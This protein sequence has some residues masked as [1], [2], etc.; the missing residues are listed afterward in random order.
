MKQHLYIVTMEDM[1]EGWTY[2]HSIAQ[3]ATILENTQKPVRAIEEIP[4]VNAVLD[5][6][7]LWTFTHEY[8]MDEIGKLL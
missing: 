4:D 8:G 2:A 6:P 7:S 3:L 5:C 1:R